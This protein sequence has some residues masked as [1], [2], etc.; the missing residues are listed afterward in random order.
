MQT[1]ALDT[2]AIVTRNTREACTVVELALESL[3]EPKLNSRADTDEGVC[4][5]MTRTVLVP[6]SAAID[7]W[8]EREV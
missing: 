5:F 3:V 7:E 1:L 8:N 6:R 4:L 2:V